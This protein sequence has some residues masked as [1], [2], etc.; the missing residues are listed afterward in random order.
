MNTPFS[1]RSR[2]LAL[3]AAL[4]CAIIPLAASAVYG[5]GYTTTT[6]NPTSPVQV[7]INQAYTI[8][9]QA[10]PSE[11]CYILY[12]TAASN[13][14]SADGPSGGSWATHGEW[15]Q[16]SRTTGQPVNHTFNMVN[17]DYGYYYW[18]GTCE[19]YDGYGPSQGAESIIGYFLTSYY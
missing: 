12:V 18:K 4:S 7:A 1:L 2:R 15:N 14:G 10:T 9:V 13:E 8:N 3:L 6:S 19:Y 11:N 5:T 17:Q 16:F